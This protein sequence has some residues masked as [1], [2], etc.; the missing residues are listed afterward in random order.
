[1]SLNKLG[2]G[3]LRFT[4]RDRILFPLIVIQG[5]TIFAISATTAGLA[6]YRSERQVIE[7]LN[8]V[9][10][11][12][13]HANFPYTSGVLSRMRGLSGAE[14]IVY[15]S[16]GSIAE[17][18]IQETKD[19]LPSLPA[20]ANPS[21]VDSDSMGQAPRI[22]LGDSSY[23]VVPLHRSS[24]R[25][26]A[27]LLVLYPEVSWR[28]ARWE[29][30]TPPLL[31]GGCSLVLMSTV[32]GWV[33]HRIGR[34]IEQINRGVARIAG[35]DFEGLDSGVERDEIGDLIGSINKMCDQLREMRETIQRSERTRLLA[36]LAAGLAHQLRN[37]LTGA[38]MSIQLHA[39]R[40]SDTGH[41]RSLDV[42]I[43][44]LSMTE[45]Q[46][47]GL[48]SLGRGESP[49]ATVCEPGKIL[50]DI[51]LL[52]GPACE[53]SH[54]NLEVSDRG[55]SHDLL[56]EESGLRAAVLN[57]VLNAIEAAGPSGMV[58][59]EAFEEG[60]QC[61]I[62]VSDSGPGPPLELAGTLFE[63]FATS[64]PEGVGLGLALAHEVALRNGGS[65]TW[66]RV[67]NWTRFRL[68]LPLACEPSRGTA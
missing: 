57:M 62:E 1:M 58:R 64:K 8:S 34:R 3:P 29:A 36:Q 66:K 52:V 28:Q 5:T 2:I 65:L 39:R 18:S 61:A 50:G 48:L 19:H 30:A 45:E 27:S 56:A 7:R 32:T 24:E 31:L 41:D 59:V 6:A 21:Q 67:E 9:V 42:A 37:S 13:E 54:V 46:V 4:I 11:T 22:R 33:A 60:G 49:P 55:I 44:Q 12:L 68:T 23:V 14:F 17:S 40:C 47:K 51:A 16:D 15:N 25:K 53:H 26:V 10:E 63:P 20:V 35:G 38:R 43:R